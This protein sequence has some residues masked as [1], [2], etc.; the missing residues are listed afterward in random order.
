MYV[1]GSFCVILKRIFAFSVGVERVVCP[2]YHLLSVELM[3]EVQQ[4]DSLVIDLVIPRWSTL[5]VRSPGLPRWHCNALRR[6]VR[7]K[8]RIELQKFNRLTLST[9]DTKARENDC[10][11]VMQVHVVWRHTLRPCLHRVADPGLVGLVS[12]VF[13]L[14]GT[15]NKR[16][17]PH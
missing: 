17:L 12:F 11:S 6:L 5:T 4:P 14:W 1:L 2:P 8:N 16:N 13:T 7:C 9:K 15:Q 3:L 10:K